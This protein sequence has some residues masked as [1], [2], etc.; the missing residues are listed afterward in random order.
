LEIC[1]L[2]ESYVDYLKS[3][4]HEYDN[5]GESHYSNMVDPY[6]D[7]GYFH[8]L[9]Q[10]LDYQD[11]TFNESQLFAV[12][13]LLYVAKFHKN[14][15]SS[16]ENMNNLINAMKCIMHARENNL[17]ME[18]KNKSTIKVQN[19]N[20]ARINERDKYISFLKTELERLFVNNVETSIDSGEKAAKVLS[21]AMNKNQFTRG[22]RWL[23]YEINQINKER[24]Y[25]IPK[26]KKA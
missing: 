12:L 3:K 25:W 15:D 20:L 18:I 17:R 4:L 11:A 26:N 23:V 7:I 13:S 21:D 5:E 1:R 16:S 19:M 2:I 10:S 24:R 9:Y 22:H 14:D 8:L 6:E